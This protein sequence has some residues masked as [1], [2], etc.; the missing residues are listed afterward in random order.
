M[1][2][3]VVGFKRV[4]RFPEIGEIGARVRRGIKAVPDKRNATDDRCGRATIAHSET[5]A[6]RK[7]GNKR[8]RDAAHG[9]AAAAA[10]RF[11]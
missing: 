10:I 9:N 7:C 8:E 4:P 11:F 6:E 1:C 2:D 5:R 3:D